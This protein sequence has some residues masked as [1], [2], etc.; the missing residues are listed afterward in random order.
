MQQVATSATPATSVFATE[1][2]CPAMQLRLQNIERNNAALAQLGFTTAPHALKTDKS[3][4]YVS[5]AAVVSDKDDS[6]IDESVG[7]PYVYESLTEDN[8]SIVDPKFLC[9]VGKKFVDR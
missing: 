1:V 5:A 2:L 7:I 8:R 9:N 4:K 6:S 3:N